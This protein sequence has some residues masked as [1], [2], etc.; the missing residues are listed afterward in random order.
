MT[1]RF[2]SMVVKCILL[3]STVMPSSPTS[4]AVYP[5]R[6]QN[7]LGFRIE[8]VRMGCRAYGHR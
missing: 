7:F 1:P 3:R 2:L 6:S 5:A 8:H 4:A